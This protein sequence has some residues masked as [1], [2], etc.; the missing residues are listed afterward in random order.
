M[1][2]DCNLIRDILSLYD[3]GE[4]CA[5]SNA[6]I[7]EHL[8]ECAECREM[9]RLLLSDDA[10]SEAPVVHDAFERSMK[11]VKRYFNMRMAL[12]V[13]L[14]LAAVSAIFISAFWGLIPAASTD[15][16]IKSEVYTATDGETVDVVFHMQ[17][18]DGRGRLRC[19]SSEST[20]HISGKE[21]RY[22]VYN[23]ARIA[24]RDT[25]YC[26]SEYAW[27]HQSLDELT[28]EEKIVFQFRDKDV[29]YSIKDIVARAVLHNEYE[30]R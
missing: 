9:H 1:R 27:Y 5:E 8:Q 17:V 28:D 16:E 30:K 2:T 22:T 15:I 4:T 26:Y 20:S 7:E 23:P 19:R 11:K 3:K 29:E 13:L 18:K 24:F 14:T 6:L 21:C 12:A 25:S 10:I